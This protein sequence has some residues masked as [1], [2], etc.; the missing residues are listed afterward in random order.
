MLSNLLLDLVC[1]CMLPAFR[2]ELYDH[3]SKYCYVLAIETEQIK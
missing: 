1:V 2:N 3:L